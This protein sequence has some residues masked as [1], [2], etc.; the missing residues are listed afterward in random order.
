TGFAPGERIPYAE[1]RRRGVVLVQAFPSGEHVASRRS[2]APPRPVA[3]PQ[4]GRGQGRSGAPGMQAAPPAVSVHHLLP[5]K[6][7]ILLMLALT[8]TKDPGEVQRF[9]DEY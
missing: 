6:A 5:Q 7:R 4:Q 3:V 9:F 1:V 8:K 2:G